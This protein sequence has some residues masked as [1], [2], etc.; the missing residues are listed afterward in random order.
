M[1]RAT[2]RSECS[3]TAAGASL[4]SAGNG[5]AASCSARASGR[6]T[7]AA[8]TAREYVAMSGL[9]NRRDGAP[10]NDRLTKGGG[11]TTGSPRRANVGGDA[12]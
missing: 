10:D 8:V 2:S 7:S 9:L 6:H 11:L 4:G 3:Y 1:T 12:R 5:V